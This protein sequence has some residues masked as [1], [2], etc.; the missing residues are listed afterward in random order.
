MT[1]KE[2]KRIEESIEKKFVD[3]AD[4]KLLNKGELRVALIELNGFISDALYMLRLPLKEEESGYY[5][6]YAKELRE[7]CDEIKELLTKK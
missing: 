4:Y 1:K 5:S 7:S 6:N 2:R 3:G